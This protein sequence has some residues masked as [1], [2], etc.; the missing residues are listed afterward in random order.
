[1]AFSHAKKPRTW[2]NFFARCNY[3]FLYRNH[4]QHTRALCDFVSFCHSIVYWNL[5]LQCSSASSKTASSIGKSQRVKWLLYQ[6]L[7]I[8]FGLEIMGFSLRFHLSVEWVRRRQ[9]AL[10]YNQYGTGPN[11][12]ATSPG[13]LFDRMHS[14]NNYCNFKEKWLFRCVRWP[15]LR[16]FMAF[17]W[18][19]S[20]RR[21][22]TLSHLNEHKRVARA[23]HS[24][25]TIFMSFVLR[26]YMDCSWKEVV[27]WKKP[28][29]K[30]EIS[31]HTSFAAAYSLHVFG[32]RFPCG[33]LH[34]R[35]VHIG[36]CLYGRFNRPEHS[37]ICVAER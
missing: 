26:K 30:Q 11:K 22:N 20:F 7:S 21:L 29:T 36:L 14:N 19:C 31:W 8:Q 28:K 33:A 16:K 37:V 32:S 3:K 18:P 1:M 27:K 17:L 25:R 10:V 15:S 23:T 34:R 9:F 5:R 4:F 35:S 6:S 24:A 12:N 13:A 2:A